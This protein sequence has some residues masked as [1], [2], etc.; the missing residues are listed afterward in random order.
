MNKPFSGRA[1][2]IVKDECGRQVARS[3]MPDQILI[4]LARP[5]L[6]F[7]NHPT[8]LSVLVLAGFQAAGGTD[9]KRVAP[10][11]AAIEFLLAAADL[12]D[13]IQD[14]VVSG[15][16]PAVGR[17]Q[18]LPEIEL[19]VALLLLSEHSALSMFE[20]GMSHE[21]VS[22][23]VS[24]LSALKIKSFNGNYDDAHSVF[25]TESKVERSV[26]LTYR[27]SGSLGRA[28]GQI[29][30][31]LAT[32]DDQLIG[33]ITRFGELLAVAAQFNNDLQ[34]VWPGSSKV[35]DIVHGRSSLP[36]SFAFPD[37]SGENGGT[38]GAKAPEMEQSGDASVQQIALVRDEVHRRGGIDFTV[39]Q[40]LIHLTKAKTLATALLARN[41]NSPLLDL[42]HEVAPSH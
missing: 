31:A 35:D 22:G 28:A 5:T 16:Q 41:S 14:D 7:S 20:S 2:D 27:K 12:L 9:N 39:L 30:A 25:E 11:A 10:A 13:D 1:L 32:D 23:A 34:D 4:A 21:R 6:L 24:L 29:G 26:E 8:F 40:I 37:G 19:I 38:P 15:D 18:L 42:L 17:S 36:L 3:G 33:S